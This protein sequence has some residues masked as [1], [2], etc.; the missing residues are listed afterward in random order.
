MVFSPSNRVRSASFI[1]SLISLMPL[2][3]ALKLMKLDWVRPAIMRARVVLPTPGGP[4]KIM[5]GTRSWSIICRRTLPSPS[6]CRW[7]TNS[8]RVRGRIRVA[9]GVSAWL[10]W[11]NVC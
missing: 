10:A 8:S 6:K 4:Q 5:E 11:K 7:P 9:S 2:V 3:T 1:T